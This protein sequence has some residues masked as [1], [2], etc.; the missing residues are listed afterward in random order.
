MNHSHRTDRSVE[1]QRGVAAIE[2]A[3]VAPFFILLMLGAADLTFFMRVKMRLEA[4]ANQVTLVVTQYENLYDSDFTGTFNI[5]NTAQ[6]IAGTTPVTGLLGATI[7]T[8]IVTDSQDRQTIAWQKRSSQATPV[9]LFGTVVGSAPVLP[10][11]YL[12]PA[13]GTLIAVEVFTPATP[14]V[15]SASVMGGGVTTTLRSYT[16]YQPRLGSLATVNTGT[17]P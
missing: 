14:W 16:L 1:L 12:L 2:F 13:N 7:V 10:N 8:G 9:S 5:F 6:T 11:N 15:F 3:L 4:T 17:R